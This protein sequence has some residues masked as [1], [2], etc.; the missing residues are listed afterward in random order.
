MIFSFKNFLNY[1][2]KEENLFLFILLIS[3][4]L[5]WYYGHRIYVDLF[6]FSIGLFGFSILINNMEN[7]KYFFKS[8]LWITFSI[9]LK[10]FNL[11]FLPISVIFL[12]YKSK[13][14]LIISFLFPVFAFLIF[15][16][17]NKYY[18][19]F[20]LTP[21]K[22]ISDGSIFIKLEKINIIYIL[23]IFSRTGEE[24]DDLR[25]YFIVQTWFLTF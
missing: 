7:K 19:N 2:K 8:L 12:A 3:N 4:P 17:V 13:F 9:L 24:S 11:I 15:I 20:F 5:I 25:A 14:Y 10:P 1:L 16:F 6:A 23:N 21:D 18:F 22:F